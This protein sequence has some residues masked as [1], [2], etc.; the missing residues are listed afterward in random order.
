MCH[1]PSRRE[2][3][4]T[5]LEL[6]VAIAIVAVLAAIAL[7]AY[8]DYVERAR[9]HQ[10]IIDIRALNV[11][12]RK[13]EDDHRD[14]PASLAPIGAAGKL[15]PW[16]RPYVYLK[17]G[18]PGTASLARKNKN[19]VPINSQFDLYSPGRDGASKPPLTAKPSHDDV[20][21]ANDGGFVGLVSDYTQ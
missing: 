21:L 2:A 11:L 6:L 13:Y 16:G 20:V 17:L 19:L 9:V 8:S 14:V 5:L 7:P 1:R 4:F 15:D 3:G 12:V 18:G 10:A